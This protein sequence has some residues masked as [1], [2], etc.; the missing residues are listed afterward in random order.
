[1]DTQPPEGNAIEQGAAAGQ[2][3]GAEQ[4]VPARQLHVVIVTGDRAVYD[5]LADSLTAP[6]TLGQITI[7]P[8]HASLLAMLEPGEMLVRLGS[9]EQ[10]L[11][12]GG[13]FI[14][15]HDDQVIVL[16]DSAE[17]AEEIDVGRAEAARQ[18]A[19]LAMHRFGGRSD[20]SSARQALRRSRARLRVARRLVRR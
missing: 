4:D 12:V 16:A 10:S 15:V 7:L 5:D 2:A 20:V 8:R 19:E 13:G 17:R 18:R 14:E 6:A 11:A 1:M 9:R 3:S